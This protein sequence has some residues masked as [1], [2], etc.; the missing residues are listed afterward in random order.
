MADSSRRMLEL[1]SLLQLRREWPGRELADR[2]AVSDRTLRR[3]IDKLRDLDYPVQAIKGPGGG[4]RLGDGARLPPLQ[5]A[6][7]EA[8][9]VAIGLSTAASS[10]VHGVGEAALRALGKL[11]QILPAGLRA[12]SQQLGASVVHVPGS[13]VV[14][15]SVLVTLA[16]ACRD[17]F[18]VRF[19]Y[20]GGDGAASLREVEPYRL[21][22][23]VGH[24]YLV[25]WDLTRQDWRTFRVDRLRPRVPLGRRFTA[26][27]LPEDDAGAYLVARVRA[28]WKDKAAILVH[29][30]V[31]SEVMRRWRTHGEV[32]AV[33]P[34]TSRLRLDGDSLHVLA[35]ML[36]ELD[37]DFTVE[38]PP[39]L[40]AYLQTVARRFA[41]AGEPPQGA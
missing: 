23:W 33:D 13:A 2:L 40:V 26:R 31:D 4:Y 38:S 14:E 24:W 16:G 9:A 7:D 21:V 37:A 6:A 17:S 11:E 19:D 18:V 1:L 8:V 36:A 29:E 12:R 20:V 15:P 22:T 34:R 32:E 27:Q 5:L 25:A 30:P 28:L 39:E 3:D 35:G 10:N 41:G